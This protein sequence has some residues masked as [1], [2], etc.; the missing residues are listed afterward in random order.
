MQ[1]WGVVINLDSSG[2]IWSVCVLIGRD[3]RITLPSGIYKIKSLNLS[4]P[5]ILSNT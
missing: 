1:F 3:L 2:G 4:T 5:V